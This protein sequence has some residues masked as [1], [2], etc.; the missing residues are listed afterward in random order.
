MFYGISMLIVF[1]IPKKEC[2]RE[3]GVEKWVHID[4]HQHTTAHCTYGNIY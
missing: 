1:K 4:H 2:E 3:T